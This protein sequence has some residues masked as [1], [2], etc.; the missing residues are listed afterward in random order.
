MTEPGWDAARAIAR[1]QHPLPVVEVPLA[2]AVGAVLAE[3]ATAVAP[4]PHYDSAAMDG[5]AVAGPPPWR[6]GATPA[7]RGAVEV[8]AGGL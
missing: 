4:V 1:E 6:V 3:D 8:V 2:A 5:W 7:A